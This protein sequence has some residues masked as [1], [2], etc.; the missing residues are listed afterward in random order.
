[1]KLK[2]VK[3]K[4]QNL[5]INK[6][7]K[8]NCIELMKKIKSNSINLIIT[9]PP[10]AIDF[11]SNRLNYNRKSENVLGGYNEIL[12]K[13]YSKFSKDW[14]NQAFR[15]L[16][17]NGSMYVFSG[18]TNLKDIL[19]ALDET[20]FTTINHLI[21][22]YQFGVY[23]SKKWVT[24]HYH[25]IYV[26]KNPKKWIFNKQDQYPEDVL[27]INREYWT[28]KIKTPTK[29]P[30]ELLKKLILY[31]SNEGDIVMD[32]FSGS[33]Q[34]A[35]VSK[36]LKRNFIAFDTVKEYVDFGNN[37]LKKTPA[38]LINIKETL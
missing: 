14:I 10:F 30:T 19:N 9:D 37:R 7:H 21:W 27:T 28:G 8:G 32:C 15:V 1:M 20:G 4:L 29:L 13:D 23:C 16:K 33:G 18:W 6:I 36:M 24:S 17:P 38:K 5:D 3:K 26:V 34:T 11:K 31:S 2:K 25:I 22:K 12:K 35:V